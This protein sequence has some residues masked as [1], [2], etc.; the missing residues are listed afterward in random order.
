MFVVAKQIAADQGISASG[1]RL[2]VNCGADANQ[3]VMHLHMH[4]VGGR[5]LGPMLPG[6]D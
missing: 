6:H 4:I 2:I 5:D 3:E 1:Y